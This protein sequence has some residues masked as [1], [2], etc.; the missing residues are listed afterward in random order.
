MGEVSDDKAPD[1]PDAPGERSFER[2]GPIV[3]GVD[4]SAVARRGL[5]FAADL[6]GILGVELVVVHSYGMLETLGSR[7]GDRY[8]EIDQLMAGEWC[9]PL[10]E[11][12][13]LRW[14]WECVHSDAVGGLLGVAER[15]GAGMIVVGSHGAGNSSAPLLGSTSHRVVRDSRRPVVVVPPD[16]NHPH[17]RRGSGAMSSVV[18]DAD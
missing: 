7:D 6:A 10:A 3:V 17:R 9:S 11:R 1:R 2:D 5:L 16:D 13:D 12:T 18:A 4:G 8:R 14:R 15:V